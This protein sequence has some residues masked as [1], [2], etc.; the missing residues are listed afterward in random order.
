MKIMTGSDLFNKDH[1]DSNVPEVF[2]DMSDCESV[3][4]IEDDD[5]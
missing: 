2:G 5:F 3:E 1:F 4:E